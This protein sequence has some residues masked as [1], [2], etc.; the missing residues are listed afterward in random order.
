MMINRGLL[1][2]QLNESRNPSGVHGATMK[3]GLLSRNEVQ[4]SRIVSPVAS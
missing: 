4:P 3:I 2:S 1:C